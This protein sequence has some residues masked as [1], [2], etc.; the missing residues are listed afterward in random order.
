MPG[1]IIVGV[2]NEIRLAGHF[3]RWVGPARAVLWHSASTVAA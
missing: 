1:V 3:A 2:V